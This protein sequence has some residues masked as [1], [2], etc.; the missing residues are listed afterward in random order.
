[1]YQNDKL[2]FGV[3]EGTIGVL[4]MLIKATRVSE[5]LKNNKDLIRKMQNSLKMII[6]TCKEGNWL[7]PSYDGHKEPNLQV[8]SG[9]PG[10]IPLCCQALYSELF[11]E[12]KG[13]LVHLASKAGVVTWEQGLLLKSTGLCHGIAGNGYVLHSLYRL[14]KWLSSESILNTEVSMFKT[15][16]IQWRIRAFMFA[17]TLCDPYIRTQSEQYLEKKGVKRLTTGKPDHP[18]SLMEGIAGEVCFLA[19]MVTGEDWMRLPGYEI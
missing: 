10:V 7:L 18:F 14:F 17:K 5:T 15:I 8:C 4:Y 12:I 13:D 3:S 16:S 6:V 9:V 19:D 11:P 1:V 2:H